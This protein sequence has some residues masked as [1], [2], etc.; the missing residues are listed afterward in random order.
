MLEPSSEHDALEPPR[1]LKENKAGGKNEIFPEVLKSYGAAM[2]EY[3]LDLFNTVWKE[4]RVLD[5][6]R[7]AMHMPVLKT[8]DLTLCDNW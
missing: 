2:I 3:I 1:K 8:G 5:E 4:D 7:S 6:L